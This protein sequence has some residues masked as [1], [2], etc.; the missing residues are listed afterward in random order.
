MKKSK[1]SA[2]APLSIEERKANLIEQKNQ[3]EVAMIKI[4]GAIEL[5]D[6]MEKNED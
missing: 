4:I 5:L 6:S 1:E 2:K 3:L